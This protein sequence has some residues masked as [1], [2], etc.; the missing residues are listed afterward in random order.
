M[1]TFNLSKKIKINTK[2]KNGSPWIV[3]AGH[4]KFPQAQTSLIL[5]GDGPLFGLIVSIN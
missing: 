5:K 4:A 1:F 3:E 2:T